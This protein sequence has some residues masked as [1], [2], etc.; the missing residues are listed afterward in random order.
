MLTVGGHA[1]RV[2]SLA[3]STDGKRLVSGSRDK[4]VRIWEVETGAEVRWASGGRECVQG[5]GWGS[6]MAGWVRVPEISTHC[7]A[8]LPAGASFHF[9]VSSSSGIEIVEG[10]G[11]RIWLGLGVGINGVAGW[12]R[13]RGSVFICRGSSWVCSSEFRDGL[14][15]GLGWEEWGGRVVK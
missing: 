9:C 11:F 4:T 15:Q 8:M 2:I 5:E 7:F 6:S 1:G 12:F 3:V 13:V 10:V 14:V